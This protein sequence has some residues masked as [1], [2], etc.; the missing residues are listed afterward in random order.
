MR[1]TIVSPII[2]P[3]QNRLGM[4]WP[5]CVGF[6]KHTRNIGF[7]WR[8]RYPP[9]E[10]RKRPKRGFVGQS[11]GVIWPRSKRLSMTTSDSRPSR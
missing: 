3:T 1:V 7:Q 11:G 10:G 4:L 9:N 5:M 6:M 2:T 8:E